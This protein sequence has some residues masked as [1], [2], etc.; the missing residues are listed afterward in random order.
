MISQDQSA[1]DLG[2]SEWRRCFRLEVAIE[3]GASKFIIKTRRF[4][5]EDKL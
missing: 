5:Y 4:N 3:Y 2:L 1:A